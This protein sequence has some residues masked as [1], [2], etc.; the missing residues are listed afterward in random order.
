MSYRRP[1]VRREAEKVREKILA[2]WRGHAADHPDH[3]RFGVTEPV[4]GWRCCGGMDGEGCPA[5][6]SSL[7]GR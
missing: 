5:T 2:E 6:S 7:E 1:D 3:A 4:A